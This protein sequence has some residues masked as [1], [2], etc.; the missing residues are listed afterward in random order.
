MYDLFC[1]A[2]LVAALNLA[3]EEVD[4]RTREQDIEIYVRTQEHEM[5]DANNTSDLEEKKTAFVRELVA[6][7]IDE[8]L[9]LRAINHVEVKDIESKDVTQGWYCCY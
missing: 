7:G 4:N 5:T 6:A 2:D 3:K 1:L 9:A 8:S